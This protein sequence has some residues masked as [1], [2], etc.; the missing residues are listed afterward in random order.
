MA[1]PLPK[2]TIASILA[3][4]IGDERQIVQRA[5]SRALVQ[6]IE[7]TDGF[8]YS[9]NNAW[10]ARDEEGLRFSYICQDS[11]QNKDRH[12]N[13]FHKTTK[14]LKG[15]GERGPRKPTYDCKGS[16]SVK[17]SQARKCVEIYYRHYAIHST[18]A[19][20]KAVKYTAKPRKVSDLSSSA[21][22]SPVAQRQVN[23]L[24]TLQGE[25]TSSPGSSIMPT[26][27]RSSPLNPGASLKRKR[28][29]DMPKLSN[30]S[31]EET[32]SLAALLQ[33]SEAASRP[34][35]FELQAKV[36]SSYSVA[37][38]VDYVLPSWQDPPPVHPVPSTQIHS[39]APV[40]PRPYRPAWNGVGYAPPY[41]PQLYQ[42]TPL[43]L[44][45][46]PP[47]PIPRAAQQQHHHPE[48]E[49]LASNNPQ[50]QGLFSTLKP[51]RKDDY[52]A[53]G[54]EPHFVIYQSNRARTSCHN[55]RVSK[56]KCDEGRPIC[57]ACARTN[58][59]ECIYE[60]API[61]RP[62]I[63][64]QPPESGLTAPKI[65]VQ[66]TPQQTASA[67]NTNTSAPRRS[68]TQPAREPNPAPW[69]P[70]R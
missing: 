13:G 6:A 55:C 9:F 51:V 62:N 1:L 65:P 59:V 60:T 48:H 22:S 24:G 7:A 67:Q 12:A 18:V 31:S 68:P 29:P 57:G 45:G 56:K 2:A 38:P 32:M 69:F 14:H 36:Q 30:N 50:P 10:S 66:E 5:A 70:K 8:K 44:T 4:T 17:F 58:K 27:S 34:S 54:S 52:T 46:L 35:A 64:E 43:C 19:D 23:L 63:W 20:R 15:E 47:V 39:I 16:V 53:T 11:M 61:G 21:T 40:Q 33:R 49:R 28:D 26:H 3:T 42:S 41:Q 37:P 25:G